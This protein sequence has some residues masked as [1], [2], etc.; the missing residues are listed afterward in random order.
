MCCIRCPDVQQDVE[1]GAAYTG[2]CHLP[3][4]Y[5]RDELVKRL[6]FVQA[7]P[8]SVRQVWCDIQIVCERGASISLLTAQFNQPQLQHLAKGIIEEQGIMLGSLL[9][10][11]TGAVW[12]ETLKLVCV[13]VPN[14]TADCCG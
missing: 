6:V 1:Q 12:K 11:R 8:D 5:Q 3:G 10:E 4:F 7:I 2:F 14:Q 9:K 13:S